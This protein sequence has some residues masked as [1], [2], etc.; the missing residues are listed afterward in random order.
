VE[1]VSQHVRAGSLVRAHVRHLNYAGRPFMRPALDDVFGSG[2]AVTL[3]E[4]T[5]RDEIDK[6]VP[7]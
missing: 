1:Q 3:I 4:R 7:A 5:L 6:R 2:R